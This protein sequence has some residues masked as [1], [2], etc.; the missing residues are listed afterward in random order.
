MGLILII[1][2]P[3]FGGAFLR[4]RVLF[5]LFPI[6]FVFLWA[7]HDRA[8]TKQQDANSYFFEETDYYTIELKK[9]VK[10]GRSLEAVV[11]DNLI[12]SFV[13][14]NDSLHLQYGYER[15]YA[16]LVAWK[17]KANPE[18]RA[19]IIGGG[20]Y[21]FPRYLEAKYPRGSNRCYR[22]R[23]APDKIGLSIPSPLAPYPNPFFQR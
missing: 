20:G 13:D 12:H 6:L 1:S 18:F 8:F 10:D 15:T 19:L 2:S 11:L 22:N 5:V 9:V 23:P 17:A 4:R 14:R 21:T 7:I 3:F 16:D